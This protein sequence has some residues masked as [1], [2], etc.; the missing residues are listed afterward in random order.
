AFHI[1]RQT[2]S[3]F[4][5]GIPS[6]GSSLETMRMGAVQSLRAS[7]IVAV[8]SSGKG[9]EGD[10][11][12]AAQRRLQ[13][14]PLSSISWPSELRKRVRMSRWDRALMLV[15]IGT[16][17]GFT[18]SFLVFDAAWIQRSLYDESNEWWNF[19]TSRLS[20]IQ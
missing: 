11:S 17:T 5:G 13:I 2:S 19:G 12:A 16:L 6:R 18:R 3:F 4:Y 14:S 7:R 10:A 9:S 20:A 15:L 8:T 1:P